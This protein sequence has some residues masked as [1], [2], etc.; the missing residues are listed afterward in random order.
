MGSE[1]QMRTRRKADKF[2]HDTDHD[3]IVRHSVKIDN[4]C[5]LMQELGTKFDDYSNKVDER[6][7]SR[8]ENFTT[9]IDHTA[10]E[11]VD[12][13]TFRWIVGIMIFA[14]ISMVAMIGVN[15]V[16]GSRNSLLIE[17]NIEHI[18][19]I[20]KDAKEFE[21]KIGKYRVFKTSIEP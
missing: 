16:S 8:L 18:K 21:K 9:K 11:A 12:E 17:A 3:L 4:L 13:N 1:N 7:E 20:E 2:V 5:K 19:E 15:Q 6:C 14:M 10:E